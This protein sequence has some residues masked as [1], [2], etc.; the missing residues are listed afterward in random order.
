MIIDV[1]E[2]IVN[3]RE[4]EVDP[5][6]VQELAESIDTIGLIS[7]IIV[8]GNVLVAGAH[9]LAAYKLRG[10]TQIACT[11]MPE[12]S[13][14]DLLKLIEIDTNLFSKALKAK[15]RTKYSAKRDD[16]KAARL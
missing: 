16:I 4:R 3:K 15:K 13:D 8:A 6:K 7:P 10:N 12:D 2:V 5:I 1:D 9:R 14:P 11:R